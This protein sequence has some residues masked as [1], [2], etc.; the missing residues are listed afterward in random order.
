MHKTRMS[1]LSPNCEYLYS[2][3]KALRRFV[4]VVYFF[5]PI[6]CPLLAAP[7]YPHVL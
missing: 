3:I 2:N 7:T 4:Q 5:E 1:I 6:S